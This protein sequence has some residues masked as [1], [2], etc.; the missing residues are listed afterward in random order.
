MA[1]L[2]AAA[3]KA[4]PKQDFAVQSK[5]GTPQGKAKGGSYPIPNASH[6]RN[7]LARSSGK[8]VA[9]KVRAA[10]A[11]KYPGMVKS[12]PPTHTPNVAKSTA[13]L[14]AKLANRSKSKTQVGF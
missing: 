14:K 11:K 3:R 10:V 13:S 2:N 8:P 5:A 6:A 4:L 1:K 7:A 12:D 9:A